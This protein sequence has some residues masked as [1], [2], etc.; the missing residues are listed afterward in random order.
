MSYLFFKLIHILSATIMIGMGF[1][2]AFYLY[3]TYR[4]GNET[5]VREV[6]RLVILADTFFTAPSVVIQ[7]VTG[8][9]L[10]EI[11]GL[12]YSRWFWQV[13]GISIVI[14]VLWIRAAYLQILMRRILDSGSQM[15]PEFHR[16]LQAWFYLGLPSFAG[17]VIL[18]YMMVYKVSLI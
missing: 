17:S 13:F 3:F 16:H 5:A 7:L 14:F 8:I 9:L 4:R 1:G 2:S 10:S 11:L 12:T 18:Y 6:L 15:T